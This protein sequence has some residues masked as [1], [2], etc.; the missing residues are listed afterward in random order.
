MRLAQVLDFLHAA[1]PLSLS[2][3]LTCMVN[4]PGFKPDNKMV[5]LPCYLE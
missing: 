1:M 2:H 3:S 5:P 4:R